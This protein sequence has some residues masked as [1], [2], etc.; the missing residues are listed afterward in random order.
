M[1]RE[2]VAA[3]HLAEGAEVGLGAIGRA[4][5]DISVGVSDLDGES[6]TTVDEIDEQTTVGAAAAVLTLRHRG[7]VQV[8]RGVG[9]IGPPVGAGR[10][11]VDDREVRV[12]IG[13]AGGAAP[14]APA[15]AA[16]AATRAVARAA[17][18]A[19]RWRLWVLWMAIMCSPFGF[20]REK[21]S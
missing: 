6:A 21:F 2:D 18:V 5:G 14:S 16:P 17:F 20:D 15:I 12:I 8:G 7:V 3:G 9:T 11:R 4:A 10:G 19:C 13:M 1:R